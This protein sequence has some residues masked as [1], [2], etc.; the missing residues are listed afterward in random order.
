MPASNTSH[1]FFEA[2]A[3]LV[4]KVGAGG[5]ASPTATTIPHTFVGLTNGNA[6]IVTANRTDSTGTTK[7]SL[8]QT[9]T[10]IGVVSSGNFINCVR[11]VEGAKQAWAADTV[12]EILL[13]ATGWNRLIEGIELEHNQDGT[14]K[15]AVTQKKVTSITTSATPTPNADTDDLFQITALAENATFGAPTGTPTNGQGLVIRIK[16]NGTARTL[17][18]NAIY[19]AIGV[20][21]PTTTV[22]S[23]TLYLGFIYNSAD[24]KWDCV[25]VQ[26]ES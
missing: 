23:K 14:H 20:S 7:N 24:D 2:K 11:E 15:K 26:Q 4:G 6:Y 12:L 5:V 21:L 3:R 18:W 13:T 22:I 19:R 17:S 9:E 10:F 25:A 8:S 16:D 1:K